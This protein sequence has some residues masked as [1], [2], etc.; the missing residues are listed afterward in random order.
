MVDTRNTKDESN[1][2]D[3]EGDSSLSDAAGGEALPAPRSHRGFLRELFPTTLC[4][5]ISAAGFAFG[6]YAALFERAASY[7]DDLISFPYGPLVPEFQMAISYIAF[8]GFHVWTLHVLCRLSQGVQ[9]GAML[10]SLA[11]GILVAVQ[12]TLAEVGQLPPGALRLLVVGAVF[13]VAGGLFSSYHSND[14]F[15]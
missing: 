8:A 10:A 13:A 5:A 14:Y 7:D 9:V 2:R 6:G 4:V 1:A 15:S 12:L 11:I 3:T